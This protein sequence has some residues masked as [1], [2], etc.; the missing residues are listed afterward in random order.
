[1]LSLSV[2]QIN[3]HVHKERKALNVWQSLGEAPIF[4]KDYLD[5]RNKRIDAQFLACL[6]VP[7][8]KLQLSKSNPAL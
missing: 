2:Q 1:M 7:K 6:S 3:T 4:C 8:R 5:T